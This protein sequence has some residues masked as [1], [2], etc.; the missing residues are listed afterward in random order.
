MTKLELQHE[1]RGHTD[2]E[3]TLI[4]WK[5]YNTKVCMILCL[6]TKKMTRFV[7]WKGNK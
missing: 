6:Q 4:H 2:R 1:R 5:N 7:L 3:T